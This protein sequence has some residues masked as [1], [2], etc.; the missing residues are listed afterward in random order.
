MAVINYI[1]HVLIAT[2]Q[3]EKLV[4]AKTKDVSTGKNSFKVSLGIMPD[5]TFDGDGVRV[6]A[7]ID[8]RPAQ[9]AGIQTGDV[10]YKLGDHSFH[11][12][13]TYMDALNKFDKGQATKV[14][15][16]RGKDDI[17]L[18]IVF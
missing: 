5:Y 15:L 18:D 1:K 14:K 3:K 9:K 10:L 17:E 11:D 2:D 7:V 12:V 4:F 16:K 6:D 8:N 13:Q